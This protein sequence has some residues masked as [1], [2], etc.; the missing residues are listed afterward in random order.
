MSFVLNNQAKNGKSVLISR[1]KIKV[2]IT[3]GIANSPDLPTDTKEKLE[4]HLQHHSDWALFGM[5]I[6]SLSIQSK[7]SK[8]K[9]LLSL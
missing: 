8:L 6:V 2:P 5:I 4:R 1:Y 7:L 3:T 9:L